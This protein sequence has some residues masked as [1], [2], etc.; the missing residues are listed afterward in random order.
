MSQEAAVPQAGLARRSRQP[1][2]AYLKHIALIIEIEWRKL[3]KDPSELVM[4]AVQPLLWLLIFGQ[5]FSQIR[6]IPTN[7]ADYMSFLSP[8]ILAQSVTFV[9]IFYGISIIWEKDMGLLQKFMSAPISRSSLMI[10]KMLSASIRAISQGFI[11]L[12]LSLLLGVHLDWSVGNVVGV[13]V[14]VI[15]GAAFFAG[16]SMTI[17]ALVKT[18]ERMMGI[19]QI[20][21]MPLFFAS[22]ALYPLSI[23]P[24]WLK[25]L[26]TVNPMSYFVDALRGLLLTSATPALVTDWAILFA[27]SA[28]VALL[29][30]WLYPRIAV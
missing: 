24:N 15:L 2:I 26:A 8:G 6:G 9:S 27:A 22:N 21:T 1:A 13:F 3:S 5:A 20:I 11:I 25:V 10:G 17:A 28:I 19:G 30:S 12:L 7:G 29:S 23:M 4:R 18:R 16:L 14:T